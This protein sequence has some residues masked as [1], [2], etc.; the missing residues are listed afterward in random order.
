VIGFGSF[1]TSSFPRFGS[2]C[3]AVILGAGGSC[4]AAVTVLPALL[5]L[6]RRKRS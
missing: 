6:R 4:L 5:S 2:L 3:L 1:V